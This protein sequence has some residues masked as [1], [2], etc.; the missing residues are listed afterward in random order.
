[1][2]KHRHKQTIPSSAFLVLLLLFLYGFSGAQA[3]LSFSNTPVSEV[4]RFTEEQTPYRFLYRDALIAG[5]RINL[6]TDAS[7]LISDLSKALESAGISARIDHD[8]FQIFLFR[9]MASEVSTRFSLTGWVVDAS[10]GSPLA[11]A[12]VSWKDGARWL[13]V[14]TN[15]HGFFTIPAIAADAMLQIR[16]LGYEPE[17]ISVAVLSDL[18]NITI[19]L[20]P[21]P[22]RSGAVIVTGQP[23]SGMADSLIHTR[24]FS[25]DRMQ[26]GGMHTLRSVSALPSV[27]LTGAFSGGIHVRGSHS[28]AFDVQL[29]GMSVFGPT[30][31]FGM[32][33]AFNAEALQAVGFFYDWIP[34]T[35]SG[36]PGATLSYL[37]R[38]G[39]RQE[40]RTSVGLSNS[41]IRA[42]TEGPLFGGNGSW[43]I[44]G[45]HSLIDQLH[46]P[47]NRTMIDWGLDVNRK[48]SL[49]QRANLQSLV[50]PRSE[51]ASFYD[52][53]V[54]GLYELQ[55]GTRITLSGYA[56]GNKAGADADRIYRAVFQPGNTSPELD[57]RAVSTAHRWGNQTLSLHVQHPLKHQSYLS[58]QVGFSRY[59]MNFS[60]DDFLYNRNPGNLSGAQTFIGFFGN[61]NE[62]LNFRVHQTIDTFIG[63]QQLVTAG[64]TFQQ[65]SIRYTEQNAFNPLFDQTRRAWQWDPFIQTAW[66]LMPEIN[67]HTGFRAHYFSDGGFI[68]FSPRIR[69]EMNPLHQLQLH[70]GYSRNYQFLHSLSL[71][72]YVMSEFWVMT[73]ASTKPASADQFSAGVVY[74]PFE[75]HVI[76]A[77]IYSKW[78]KHTRLPSVNARTLIAASDFESTPWFSNNR[79][80]SRGVELQ[81]A[82]KAG[83]LIQLSNSYTWSL[84]EMSNSRINRGETFYP[85]WDRRHQGATE[86]SLNATP[87][88]QLQAQM[89]WASGAYNNLH[90]THRTEPERLAPYYRLDTGISYTEKWGRFLS[91]IRFGI[92]NVLNRDNVIYRTTTFYI[93]TEPRPRISGEIVNVYDLGI[94]PSIDLIVRF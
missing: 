16:Y 76:Q 8:R 2:K 26:F 9:G 14:S 68:R 20:K 17:T 25:M 40:M 69:L 24:A 43:L 55:Q 31:F 41:S 7:A 50:T 39:S 6:T 4:I 85:E 23:Y 32:F 15:D 75:N 56:G 44:S 77:D 33:D 91:S 93:E 90:Q 21:I 18:P 1:M 81:H 79:V 72:H 64:H 19:R 74:K 73:T 66:V 29:D 83:K 28:D 62:L 12:T 48:T 22:L 84:T 13:G 60:R 94:M 61:E 57:I 37:T 80:W 49:Q 27:H 36:P 70:A 10:T 11:F 89:V 51:H 65:H 54:K 42:T 67:L 86:I 3:Q 58:T 34:A 38:T 5:V 82:M 30:H 52:V 87:K 71:T 46:W 45:R 88:L 92:Y 63:T 35:F 78:K 53:H 59:Q 47:G